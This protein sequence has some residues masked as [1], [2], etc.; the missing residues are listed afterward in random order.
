MAFK[1]KYEYFGRHQMPQ[2]RKTLL[3]IYILYIL[4]FSI[5]TLCRLFYDFLLPVI[6][7]LSKPFGLLLPHTKGI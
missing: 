3:I 1:L 7:L 5:M 4:Y 2:R 6:G